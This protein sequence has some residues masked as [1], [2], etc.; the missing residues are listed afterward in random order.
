M[1]LPVIFFSGTVLCIRAA[2]GFA[3]RDYLSGGYC[4]VV[5]NEL[6]LREALGTL[7]D[8]LVIGY[9]S[10]APEHRL[11]AFFGITYTYAWPDWPAH[12]I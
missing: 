6:H 10:G 5:D 12:M 8:I 2:Q 11:A 7:L 9:K 4:G 1:S 3:D